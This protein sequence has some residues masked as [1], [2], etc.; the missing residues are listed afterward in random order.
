MSAYRTMPEPCRECARREAEAKQHGD[1]PL[2]TPA[3]VGWA[4]LAIGVFS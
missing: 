3:W 1:D 2:A 4:L